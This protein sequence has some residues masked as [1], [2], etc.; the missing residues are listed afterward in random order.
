MG[1]PTRS[2]ADIRRDIWQIVPGRSLADCDGP[3]EPPEAADGG[4]WRRTR[5]LRDTV[6]SGRSALRKRLM[7]VKWS[8]LP[9]SAW[10]RIEPDGE[11]VRETRR[12]LDVQR[13]SL[14]SWP[15]RRG[16]GCVTERR[17]SDGERIR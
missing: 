10:R 15:S 12:V 6:G 3:G 1:S 2:A 17:A 11:N 14:P 5:E 13:C 8:A 7:D 4:G 16:S 9:I